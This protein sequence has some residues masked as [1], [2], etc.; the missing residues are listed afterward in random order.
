MRDVPFLPSLFLLLLPGVALAQP[1]DEKENF[2]L[3][4]ENFYHQATVLQDAGQPEA[5]VKFYNEALAV[6]AS[7]TDAWYNLGL[8]QYELGNFREAEVA[9]DKLMELSPADTGNYELYGLVLFRCGHYDRAI[10]SYNLV[11]A[12]GPTDALYVNRALAYLATGRD[13]QALE[14]FEEALRLNYSNANACLGKGIALNN[15][16]QSEL[17]ITWLD[18][19][20]ELK[21][22]NPEILS[23]RAIVYFQAGQKEKAMEDFR[24]ALAKDRKSEIFAARARCF[25]LEGNPDEAWYDVRE[26]LHFDPASAEL[27]ELAGEIEWER[28][29]LAAGIENFSKVL[30]MDPQNYNCYFKRS[31]ILLQNHQFYEAISDLYRVIEMDPF[32]K[33]ARVSLLH[34]YSR[35]D[36]ENLSAIATK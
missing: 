27:L 18:R 17:A 33:E 7:L 25:L 36:R 2:R 3:E 14:D 21:P 12:S 24:N 31:K 9:L 35:L 13:K 28:G 8:A 34:A 20:L 4:A 10:A 32:N 6:D 16:G 15:L 26:A 5:A 11:I 1:H 19:A 29:N 22:G 30:E 23:N